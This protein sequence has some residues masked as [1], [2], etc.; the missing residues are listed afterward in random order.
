MAE[1]DLKITVT[2]P[3]ILRCKHAIS[4]ASILAFARA[5]KTDFAVMFLL[6]V[7]K[8]V[9]G[10][11]GITFSGQLSAV[12]EDTYKIQSLPPV[13]RTILRSQSGDLEHSPSHR[14]SFR[15]TH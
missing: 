9:L 2:S 11:W 14:H 5:S 10:C 7:K 12:V 1:I 4:A 15:A 3:F 6:G 8:A 13:T